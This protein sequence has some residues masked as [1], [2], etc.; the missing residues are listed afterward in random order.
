MNLEQKGAEILFPLHS[1][2]G[3]APPKGGENHG[4]KERKETSKTGR[5]STRGGGKKKTATCSQ[6][7]EKIKKGW[8]PSV[9]H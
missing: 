6:G 8:N 5:L 7:L 4:V 3:T 1:A 9:F 2:E